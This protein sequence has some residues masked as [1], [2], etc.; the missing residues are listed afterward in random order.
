MDSA[1]WNRFFGHIKEEEK[2]DRQEAEEMH[3][4][5]C[6]FVSQRGFQDLTQWIDK[7]ISQR[8]VA[9]GPEGSMLY[10]CGVRDGLEIIQK[11]LADLQIKARE[12][13]T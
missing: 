5:I 13:I 11:H 8:R 9:P 6:E 10:A 3:G 4:R 2:Q 1:L 7:E 12:S